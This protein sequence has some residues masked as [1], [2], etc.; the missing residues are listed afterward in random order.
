MICSALAVAAVAGGAAKATEFIDH[1]IV[2]SDN[3]CA[4]LDN[5]KCNQCDPYHVIKGARCTGSYCDNMI[6]T[7][8]DPPE[9][10]SSEWTV[11]ADPL[12]T[13]WASD[14]DGM[15]SM[16]AVCP[17]GYAMV[18]MKS[19]GNYSDNIQSLCLYVEHVQGWVGPPWRHLYQL[20]FSI[21]DENRGGING[22]AWLSGASCTGSYCDNM[23]YW[24]TDVWP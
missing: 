22:Y 3:W 1:T 11:I 13:D 17:F 14:E 2:I 21:S 5:V 8:G 7:C 12:P 20:P 23:Y 18:G 9:G 16:K 10:P 6:Y 4:S 24:Y 19:T 15:A